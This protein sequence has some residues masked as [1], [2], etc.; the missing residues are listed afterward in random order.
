MKSDGTAYL[1]E[2]DYFAPEQHACGCRWFECHDWEGP[3]IKPCV[4]IQ[5][6]AL[7]VAR[8]GLKVLRGRDLVDR[9]VTSTGSVG[10]NPP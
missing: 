5:K 4:H 1:V 2:L 10:G 6:V 9:A 8:G 3:P 7:R